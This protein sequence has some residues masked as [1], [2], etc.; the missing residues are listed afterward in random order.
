MGL[1]PPKREQLAT[2]AGLD[3]WARAVP[4][5]P[6]LNS[7]GTAQLQNDAVTV[8]KLQNF[9]GVSV[10]VRSV[11]GSG[12]AGFVTLAANQFLVNRGGTL[13]SAGLV[14]ADIPDEITRDTE[15]T[16][17]V[18]DA[19]DAHEAALNPHPQ[20][21]IEA[22]LAGILASALA[23]YTQDNQSETI[24]AAWTF[25]N[26]FRRNS[27]ISPSALASGS[28][29]DWNPTGLSSASVIRVL[30]DNA[31][32]ALTGI[33]AVTGGTELLVINLGPTGTLTLVYE[34]ANST[35]GNR[36]L[37]ASGTNS[38]LQVGGSARLW[39]DD[40]SQR[41]RHTDRMS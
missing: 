36:I 41:W 37:T 2:Q 20:Y 27:V 24:T 18:E 26:A 8:E 39:Y 16:A 30:S 33:A 19:V 23:S 12:D 9:P 32:S 28:T 3:Q 35:A 1:L 13:T 17:A 29:H 34:D 14:V 21:L 5:R 4:V 38:V 25:A 22:T 40:I 10:L 31:N 7:V 11:A 15:L 6:D